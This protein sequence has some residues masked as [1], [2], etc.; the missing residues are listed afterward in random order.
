MIFLFI[1][2]KKISLLKYRYSF[3]LSFDGLWIMSP[4]GNSLPLDVLGFSTG[5]K[6]F[7]VLNFS[8]LAFNAVSRSKSCTPSFSLIAPFSFR[9]CP[10][11]WSF[12]GFL[13]S[14]SRAIAFLRKRSDEDFA[15]CGMRGTARS[16]C[17]CSVVIRVF[18]WQKVKGFWG[19]NL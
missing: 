2:L 14:R 18:F 15:R 19:S 16:A 9:N 4:Y 13:V 3:I 17:S 8:M 11:L 1:R 10:I 12:L 7:C 6:L 5:K